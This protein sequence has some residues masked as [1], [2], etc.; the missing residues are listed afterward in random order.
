MTDHDLMYGYHQYLIGN[1]NMPQ[2][3]TIPNFP[4]ISQSAHCAEYILTINKAIYSYVG[5]SCIVV[6]FWFFPDMW[7]NFVKGLKT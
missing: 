3:Y 2:C 7:G 1:C 5:F 4:Y 6:V